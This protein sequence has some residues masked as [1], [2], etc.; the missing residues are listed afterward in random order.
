MKSRAATFYLPSGKVHKQ[1]SVRQYGLYGSATAATL[2]EIETE[3]HANAMGA[4]ANYNT[5]NKD[6]TR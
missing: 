4:R 6:W 5:I 2:C 3:K 1:A